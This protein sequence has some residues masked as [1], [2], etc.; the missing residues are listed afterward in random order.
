MTTEN[1]NVKKYYVFIAKNEPVCVLGEYEPDYPLLDRIAPAMHIIDASSPHDARLVGQEIHQEMYVPEG[2]L[3]IDKV[4]QFVD[5]FS[6]VQNSVHEIAKNKGWWDEPIREDGT[7]IALMH[8]ELSELLEALR[9]PGRPA[10]FPGARGI[11][12]EEE[13]LADLIIRA[14]D[15]AQ[16]KGYVL[17]RAI[18]AKMSYNATRP[19]KHG[20]KF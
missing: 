4:W 17:G 6:A 19:H 3:S 2:Q 15:F 16:H 11:S 7:V 9:M 13:E 14:M 12:N 18:A 1:L 8:S 5:A 10:E 20:K